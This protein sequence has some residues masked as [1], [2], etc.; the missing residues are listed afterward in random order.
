MVGK[1]TQLKPIRLNSGQ[2]RAPDFAPPGQSR[3][4]VVSARLDV[5]RLREAG[6]SERSS[7]GHN[8]PTELLCTTAATGRPAT[9]PPDARPAWGHYSRNPPRKRRNRPPSRGNG[10]AGSR[11]VDLRVATGWA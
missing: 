4:R 8:Q 7:T 10:A 11:G 1:L 2:I 5:N 3:S 6:P 9:T